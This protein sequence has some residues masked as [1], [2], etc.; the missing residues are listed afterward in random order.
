MEERPPIWRVPANIFN[1]QS[2]TADKVWSSSL[3]VGPGV[4][5][6]LPYKLVLLRN[7]YTCLKP[8]LILW[9]DLSNGEGTWDL[10]RGMYVAC[11]GPVHLQQ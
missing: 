8:E 1:K 9:Y 11:I 10:V 7:V 3:S 2:R 4:N 5:S 6:S